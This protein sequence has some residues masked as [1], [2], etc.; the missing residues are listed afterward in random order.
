MGSEEKRISGEVE[1]LHKLQ[2]RL[3]QEKFIRKG[4]G[5]SG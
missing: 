5:F 2:D 1:E 4:P 3:K